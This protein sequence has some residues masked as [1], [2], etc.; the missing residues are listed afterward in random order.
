[1][2]KSISN[3]KKA[4]LYAVITV[5][6]TFVL[7][8]IIYA[9]APEKSNSTA[10]ILFILLNLIPMIMAFLFTYQSKEVNGLWQFLEKVFCGEER[11]IIWLFVLLVPVV[12]YG[13]SVILGN[14]K[15]TG[16]ALGAVIAYFPWTLFQGGLEE[17]G[18]RW[19]LQ[20]HLQCKNF[21]LKMFVISVIWFVW[22]LP[23]YRLPWITAG[24]TSY[25]L[26]YLM[27]L[28]NTFMLGAIKEFSK[29]AIPCVLAHMLIDSL[30]ILMLVKSA[31][32]PLIILVVI[33]VILSIS[34]VYFLKDKNMNA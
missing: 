3:N 17:V 20:E 4:F 21:I 14:V 30:A 15:F 26:F 1:M 29:G 7:G 6:C 16:M 32:V 5:V 24:S 12:Y 25:L 34:A 33:E 28:G 10:S 23:I 11:S 13:V 18:W 22:H 19:Y 27:I 31:L 9:I 2:D 8:G